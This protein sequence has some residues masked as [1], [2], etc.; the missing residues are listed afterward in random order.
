[1]QGRRY[2]RFLRALPVTF[3]VISPF[4]L[5]LQPLAESLPTP[6]G[7]RPVLRIH[8]TI[9]AAQGLGP[10]LVSGFLATRKFSGVRVED[11]TTPL[12]KSV[13]AKSP[14]GVPIR[15]ELIG[16]GTDEGFR[17]LAAGTADIAVS[18]RHIN[19]AEA[20]Q[21]AKAGLGDLRGPENGQVVALDAIAIIVNNANPITSLT[22]EDLARLFSGK[23]KNWSEVDGPSWM[24]HIHSLDK[25]SSTVGLL[26]QLILQSRDKELVADKYYPTHEELSKAVSADPGGIGFVTPLLVGPNKALAV[27][28]G[29]YSAIAPTSESIATEDYPFTRRITFYTPGADKRT[30][31]ADALVRFI[32]GP[33]GQAIVA[34][35]GF[36][37]QQPQAFKVK[38]NHKM[39]DGYRE[40]AQSAQR[41]S[42]NFRFPGDSARLGEKGRQDILRVADYVRSHHVQHFAL[43]S[44][45]GG[46]KT[47][48]ERANAIAFS[49][50]LAVRRA[51]SKA[52]VATTDVQSFGNALPIAVEGTEQGRQRNQRVEV[53]VY[54]NA[55]AS[56]AAAPSN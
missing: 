52:G 11:G 16:R 27:S 5:S 1:M 2:F 37:G 50:G 54:P 33:E 43:A 24:V 49:Q 31:W 44:F 8:G 22:G 42:V 13:T 36:V 38:I 46:E 56:A 18:S 9:A 29:S 25:D 41:L 10:D 21:L 30:L 26:D 48:P 35:A 51:L 6:N 53:W 32:Q 20:T 55:Q 19:D 39:P 23:I 17:D 4:I 7:G 34:K 47:R 45:A 15:I 28:D 40:L 3:A 12:E 14:E